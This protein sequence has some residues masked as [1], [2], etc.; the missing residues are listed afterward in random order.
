[1]TCGAPAGHDFLRVIPIGGLPACH[2]V[3]THAIGR[4]RDMDTVLAGGATTV[5]TTG[6]VGGR[7]KTA[8][9]HIAGRQPRRGLV[10]F[11]A[12]IRCCQMARWLACG[13]VPVMTGGASPGHD[14]RVIE[15]G[16]N[17]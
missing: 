13:D 7:G 9:I 6:T 14:A 5:M 3:T 8:V 16:T 15:F 4:G 10:T 12:R 17:K 2:S 11:I 1:M